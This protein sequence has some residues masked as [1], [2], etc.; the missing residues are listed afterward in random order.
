MNER[1]DRIKTA[2]S[3]ISSAHVTSEQHFTLASDE[4]A[5]GLE[6][7]T[8][9]A[10]PQPLK[11]LQASKPPKGIRSAIAGPSRGPSAAEPGAK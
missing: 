5:S 11:R 8:S 3:C 9:G 10:Q 1:K 7:A 4:A 6:A 2:L